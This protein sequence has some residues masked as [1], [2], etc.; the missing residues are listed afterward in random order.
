ML[1]PKLPDTRNPPAS[2]S[3][4]PPGATAV[5]VAAGAAGLEASATYALAEE[6]ATGRLVHS[7]AVRVAGRGFGVWRSTGTPP[8]SA[9]WRG[10]PRVHGQGH[11]LALASGELWTPPAPRAAPPTGPCPRCRAAVR[12]KIDSKTGTPSTWKHNR[13]AAGEGER[14]TKVTCE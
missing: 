4:I 6:L 1:I 14:A 9:V 11:L 5:L 12:W 13:A 10:V 7:V 8:F 2:A 3:Q